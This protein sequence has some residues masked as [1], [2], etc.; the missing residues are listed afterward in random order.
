[1]WRPQQMRNDAGRGAGMSGPE[2]TSPLAVYLR[3][4]GYVKPYRG[5]FALGM[6]GGLMYAGAMTSFAYY[7]KKFTD[8]TW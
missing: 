5:A 4:L 6:F 8:G 7:A 1:M 3:L 2:T